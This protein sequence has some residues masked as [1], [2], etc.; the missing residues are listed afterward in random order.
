MDSRV[1]KWL[2]RFSFPLEPS[3]AAL[4]D[5]SFYEL[6]EDGF[7]TLCRQAGVL[8]C[9]MDAAIFVSFDSAKAWE[10]EPTRW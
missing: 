10:R 5:L 7:Q 3:S 6:V 9:L 2:R 8:P 4:S 1:A